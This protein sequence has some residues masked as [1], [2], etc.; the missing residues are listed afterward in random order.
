M[1]RKV[2]GTAPGMTGRGI[3][4]EE[5]NPEVQWCY[6]RAQ[7]TETQKR[8]IVSSCCEIAVRILFENFVYKFG[9]TWYQK[10]SGG[11]IG[12]KITIVVAR[13]VMSDWGRRYKNILVEAGI[14]PDLLG[15]YMDDGRQESG[16]LEL[17]MEFDKEQRVFIHS[18]ETRVADMA[19]NETNERRMARICLV[20]MT[21][22]CGQSG[23]A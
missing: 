3:N 15:G 13:L 2:G 22:C 6:P 1:R 11:P 4:S 14:P 16:V 23:G 21:S 20:A 19:R 10:A 5:D 17:G 8:Q 7:P 18:E 12:A 9:R